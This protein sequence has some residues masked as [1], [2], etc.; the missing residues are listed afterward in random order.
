M[1]LAT[2]ALAPNCLLCGAPS[3]RH[4]ALIDE[5]RYWNCRACGLTFLDPSDRMRPIEEQAYYRL[6]ANEP[7]DE[8]YLAAVERL[9]SHLLPRLPSGAIG[10]DYGCGA[11]GTVGRLMRR[12]DLVM[13]EYDPVF[14]DHM[15]VLQGKY[16]FITCAEAISHFHNPARDFRLLSN[17][18]RPGGW[19]GILSDM[20]DHDDAFMSWRYRHDPS[21]VVFYRPSSFRLMAG[22]FGWRVHTPTRNV[23][24]LEKVR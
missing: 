12:H 9:I 1:Q 22:R 3:A 16:D 19:I 20:L 4:F 17:M 10:L 18:L 24:L 23:V 2:S 14:A 5:K 13:A 11:Q 21:R 15:P 8:S 7:Q 6:H